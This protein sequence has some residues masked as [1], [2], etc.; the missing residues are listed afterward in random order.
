M[1]APVPIRTDIPAGKLR[2]LARQETNGR[3]ACRLLAL[4]NVLDGMSREDAAG[5]AG[6][7]RQTLRDW[8]IRFNAEGIEGLRDRPKSGR[9][10]WL[11]DGQLA[12]LK[13]LVLRG[14]D[15]ERDGVSSWRAK[16]LCRLVEA[17][18]GVSYTEN[19]MLRLLHDL[20]LSW[21]K[22]R[23]VH[24]EADLKAQAR[25]KKIPGVDRRGRPRPPRS[26]AAR[27]LVPRRGPGRPDRPR[28]PTLV[29]EGHAPARRARP[30]P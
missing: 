4:A 26:R 5:R 24:P 17:R 28:L 18:F 22:A 14:P 12:A 25:F 2:R 6:M 27:G 7:D 13:A 10:A 15:P 21:Q 11:G 8:V 23:P 1:G 29:R 20:G 16:D 30:A 9:P 3:V 19:G